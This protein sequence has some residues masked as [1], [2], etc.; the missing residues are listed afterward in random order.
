M[1]PVSHIIDMK[2][3]NKRCVWWCILFRRK[4]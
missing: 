1:P 2:R 3:N 4:L